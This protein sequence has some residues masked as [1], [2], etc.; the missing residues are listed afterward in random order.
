MQTGK[1]EANTSQ[2]GGVPSE[3]LEI[4]ER[5]IFICKEAGITVLVGMVDA[6]SAGIILKGVTVEGR[7]LR[8]IESTDQPTDS[9]VTD[10]VPVTD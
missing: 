4:L 1:S 6:G 9:K 3:A 8:V 10:N 5:A 2:P 7:R